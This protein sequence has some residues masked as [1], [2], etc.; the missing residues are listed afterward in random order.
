MTAGSFADRLSP[1]PRDGGFSMDGDV[2]WGTSVVRGD[3]GAYHA[4]A[5]RW[6]MDVSFGCWTTNSHVVR[7]RADAP[8]GPFEF[9]GYVVPPGP[10]GAWDRM[11]HNPSITRAPDGTYLLY[12]Y[13]CRFEGPRP[14]PAS[15]NPPGRTGCSIGLATA[16]SIEGSWERHGPIHGGTNPVPVV[17]PDGSVRVYTRDADF[18]MS[19]Y[20]ADH[21]SDVDGYELLAEN[22]LRPVEDHF[23]WRDPDGGY[24]AV[25]KDMHAH[26]DDHEGYG[27]SYAG[28]HATSADGLE[29]TVSEPPL[30]YP[31]RVEGDRE[32]VVEWDDYTE[33]R[34]PNVERVQVLIE[35]GVP[36]CLYLA[37]LEPGE[38]V[39]ATHDFSDLTAHVG[40]PERVWN[41]AIPIRP[42]G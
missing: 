11:S 9:Q 37:V 17:A 40:D 23:V 22:V 21:W 16:E 7:G 28:I 15:P 33:T 5:S 27:P 42:P 1:A 38:A 2:I 32:L 25:A 26:V 8:E 34:Y 6:S 14:T 18:E 19:V 36:T 31:H 12:Y 20:A 41:L 3:D 13:G 35:D 30:A 39:R 29:W 24:Q 4:F 10:E